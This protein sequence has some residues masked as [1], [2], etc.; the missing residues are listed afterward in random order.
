[1]IFLRAYSGFIRKSKAAAGIFLLPARCAACY[2]LLAFCILLALCLLPAEKARASGS[3]EV[4]DSSYRTLWH[5]D[6]KGTVSDSYYRTIAHLEPNGTITNSYYQTLGR[7][8]GGDVTDS[9][10]RTLGHIRNG[11][12]T[13]SY[14]R[15]IGYCSDSGYLQGAS[16]ETLG[17]IRGDSDRR[18][19]IIALFYFF[20]ESL[21]FH[22]TIFTIQMQLSC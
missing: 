1:M 16:Y 2:P 15:T 17:H 22:Y 4:T 11:T 18:L 12:V 14:Y 6:E 19:M 20:R 13:D 10:Y 8:E 3:V 5:I 21:A 9:Y 7:V